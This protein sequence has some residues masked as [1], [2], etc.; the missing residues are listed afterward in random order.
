MKILISAYACEPGKGSEPE[1]GL[2]VV[3]A[4]AQ[5]HE[6]WVL[7]RRNNV[8]SLLD[9][10]ASHPYRERVHVEGLDVTG[11]V[12]R[13]K[14]AGLPGLHAY[15]DAW[16]RVA[17]AHAVSLDRRIRFDVVHHATFATFWTRAGVSGVAK[18]MVWG[19]VGGGVSTPLVL[20]S[21]LGLAGLREEFLREVVRR[22][23]VGLPNH[24]RTVRLAEA[25]LA[26]NP[27]TARL[28]M[29]PNVSVLPNA[30][31]VALTLDEGA[32][33]RG[34]EIAFVGRL[35]PWKA[36]VL[37][38][39]AMRYVRH[40]GATLAIYGDGP[41]RERISRVIGKWGLTGRVRLMGSL[42]R[43]AAPTYP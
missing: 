9:Y 20:A 13:V 19:P 7:T 18:P 5:L 22:L 27:E 2:R 25:I 31:S 12:R 37:A 23:A 32:V 26:Q 4:A 39:R 34:N 15:Y 14:S 3:L 30:L 8:P 43:R 38:V 11:A 36:G 40:T 1:V 17:G 10:L 6:V 41:D 16:Q 29:G 33:S 35:A 21:E 24:R 42:P 28:I